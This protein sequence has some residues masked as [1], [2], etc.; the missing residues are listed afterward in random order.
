MYFRSELKSNLRWNCNSDE[1]QFMF[2][3]EGVSNFLNPDRGEY[4]TI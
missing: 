2:G 3:L 4:N 1:Y